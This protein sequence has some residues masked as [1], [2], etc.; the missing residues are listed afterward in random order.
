MLQMKRLRSWNMNA[1]DLDAAVRFYRDLLGGTEGRTANIAGATVAHVAVG[2]V[3]L[4][5][6]DA[7]EGPRPGVPHHTVEIEW[8]GDVDSLVKELEG[9]GIKVEATRQHR[10]DA[11]YSVYVD[12]PC[13][14]RIELARA[15]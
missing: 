7:S 5:L 13:G 14:N 12:D 4:G 10:E 15:S 9:R 3:T 1:P 8:D 6:F 2:D 11:G